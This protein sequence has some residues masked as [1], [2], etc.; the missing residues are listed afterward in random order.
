M[1]SI[2]TAALLEGNA[3]A[4]PADVAKIAG[5]KTSAIAGDIAT[6][7]AGTRLAVVADADAADAAMA[8]FPEPN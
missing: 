7:G 3:G 4:T 1:A 6:L 2:E 8:G 5:W